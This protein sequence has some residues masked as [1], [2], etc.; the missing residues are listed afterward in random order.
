M[1]VDRLGLTPEE[2]ALDRLRRIP[3]SRICG[4]LRLP[5]MLVGL[6]VGDEQ[7]TFSNYAQARRAGYEDCLG[8]MHRRFARQLTRDLLKELGGWV[9]TTVR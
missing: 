5:A 7:R 1:R 9:G 8:P 4:A 6:S 2:L 3:E